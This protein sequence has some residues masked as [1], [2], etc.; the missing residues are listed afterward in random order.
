MPIP[1]THN[2][3][4]I[5]SGP[6][7]TAATLR[8]MESLVESGSRDPGVVL[9]AQEVVRNCPEYGKRA[10]VEAILASARRT[11]RY[12][13]EGIETVK[14]PTF[15]LEEIRRKGRAVMDCD[16]V[17]VWVA[18]LLRAVGLW[19]RFKVIQDDPREYTHVF[20]E[21]N[22]DGAWV[23]IDPIARRM[24]VGQE[25]PGLFGS[26]VF[27]NGRLMGTRR[28]TMYKGL[29][30]TKASGWDALLSAI[31]TPLQQAGQAGVDYLKNTYLPGQ[32]T[33]PA[34]TPLPTM[35]VARPGFF[36]KVDASGR[37]VT[38]PVKVG[39]AVAV[40][41]GLAFLVLR[42]R[43]NPGRRRRSSRRR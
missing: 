27:E 18:T 20:L 21:V 31:A 22:L 19:T 11:M 25:P 32:K 35:P 34:T 8:V 30:E 9:Y 7:G 2:L 42:R 28:S 1:F 24:R 29:G 33:L 39:G 3:S 14:H 43:R 38:D 10:E 4:T 40:V 15:I 26:A 23:P 16:D 13:N 12:T 17:S 41:G 5:P 6:R 36:Q 37:I